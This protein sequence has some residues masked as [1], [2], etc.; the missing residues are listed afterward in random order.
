MTLHIRT[1]TTIP[2]DTYETA[3]AAFPKGNEYMRLRDE[4]GVVY[5]DEQYAD[6]YVQQ[7]QDAASPALLAWVTVLQFKENW[8]DRDAAE[9]VRGRIDIKYLLGLPL[10]DAGFHH[11]ALGEFRDRLM[12]NSAEQRLL[13]ELLA[14]CRRHGLL[15]AGG[16]Q[17]TDSTPVLAAVRNLNRLECVGETLRQALQHLAVV[18]PEWLQAQIPGEWY[19]W[20]DRRIEAAQLAKSKSAE[21]EWQVR[22][23]EHGQQ[24][25]TAL[26]N[27]RTPAYL[28]EIPAIHLL[29]RV[30]LQQYVVEAERIRWRMESDGLPPGAQFIQS[31]YDPEARFRT[32]RQ[33]RWSGYMVHLTETHDDEQP[34]LVINVETVPAT[35]GDVNVTAEIHEHLAA[36]DLLPAEHYVDTGYI[37]AAH[38]LTSEQQGIDLIG[39][40]VS[41]HSW[42]AKANRGFAVACFAIDWAA[43]IATCPQGKQS[44]SWKERTKQETATVNICFSRHDC[45]PCALRIQCLKPTSQYRTLNIHTQDHYRVLHAAR[46]RQQTEA[47]RQKYKRRA[48]IEGTI[49]QAVRSF[50]ARRT[51]YI[52]RAKTHLQEIAAAVGLNFARLAD[53]FDPG[54]RSETVRISH[55][56]RLAPLKC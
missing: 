48:G 46:Q 5:T 11:S 24:L 34:H 47:F 43:R 37:S 40:T 33:T 3:I 55:F 12:E 53:W 15:K 54:F 8:S 17:R 14:V 32:K 31:P 28:R 2:A 10:K 38:L 27:E 25:L 20:Y 30:W 7:G 49:S 41:D 42:Q 23:G 22:I 36:R 21:A 16:R 1:D 13:D 52:G 35:T 9:A 6:L 51:R 50:N 45:G 29:Q 56:T 39:P 18:A 4:L 26:Y 19:A 44:R